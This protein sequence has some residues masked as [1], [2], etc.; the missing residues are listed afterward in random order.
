MKRSVSRYSIAETAQYIDWA[1]LLHAWGL[2]GRATDGT[3]EE[4]IAEAK[5]MLREMDGRYSCRAIFA[6]CEARGCN[7]DIIIE[8]SPL[9]LLRQQHS[10]VGEPNLCLSDFVSP[11]GD[12]IGLFATA[13]D[14]GFGAEYKDDDYKYLLAQ[15]VADRLAEATATYLHMQVRTSKALWGY[16]PDERLTI[17]ELN[18]EK[19]Q[20]IRPAVGYPSLPDQSIIFT[21]DKLLH[22]EEAGIRLTPNGAMSPHAAVCGIMIKHPAAKYFA[23][24][25]ISGEQ[26][27]DYAKRRGTKA[28]E[29]KKFLTKN[30]HSVHL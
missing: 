9:P 16:A 29:I 28:E 18:A 25:E 19:Y 20:G 22:L 27:T 26:L 11:H 8:D 6:L 7:D 10:R 24:G 4:V 30:L 1:Y 21:I 2:T 12:H 15:T 5:A 23:V 3:A 14:N 17:E 13:V